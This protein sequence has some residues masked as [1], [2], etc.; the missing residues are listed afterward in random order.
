MAV[1]GGR[2]SGF[3][4]Y[5]KKK[6]LSYGRWRVETALQMEPSLDLKNLTPGEG[7]PNGQTWILE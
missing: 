3:R 7:V 2:E 4:T 1:Q 6:N 5:T